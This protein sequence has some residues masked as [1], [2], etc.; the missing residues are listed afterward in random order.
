MK[1]MLNKDSSNSSIPP[2]KDEKPKKKKINLREKSNKKTGKSQ[3]S[4]TNDISS[5]QIG[6]TDYTKLKPHG[7]HGATTENVKRYI[8]FAAENGFD[9]VLAEGWNIGWE[10]WFGR[11]KDFVYDF[12]TPYPD[13]DVVGIHAYA[14]SKGVKMIMH[15]ETSSS[16]R[17]YERH[18]DQAYQFMKDN[19]YDAVKSGYVGNILPLRLRLLI[20]AQVPGVGPP[21]PVERLCDG[22]GNE[23]HPIQVGAALAQGLPGG[24]ALDH[25]LAVLI[26]FQIEVRVDPLAATIVGGAEDVHVFGDL[27][28]VLP[29]AVHEKILVRQVP[30]ALQPIL[31]LLENLLRGALAG[32]HLPPRIVRGG[33]PAF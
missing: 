33:L 22:G 31:Q 4:Y 26:P 12:V 32:I 20:P 27:P 30:H 3:W 8:D 14:K 29:L 16:V 10:D 25:R 19:G 21:V 28:A 24:K 11:S 7:K 13:F 23:V 6:V 15:H 2:S 18:L 1:A 17:N 9:G 5:V